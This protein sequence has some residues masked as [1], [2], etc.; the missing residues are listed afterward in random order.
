MIAENNRGVAIMMQ[1]TPDDFKRAYEIFQKLVDNRPDWLDVKVNAAIALLNMPA[2]DQPLTRE[3][4]ADLDRALRTFKEVLAVDPTNARANYCAGLLLF[5][6]GHIPEALGYFR[7]AADAKPDDAYAAYQ[8]ATCLFNGDEFDEALRWYRKAQKYDPFLASAYYG[9]FQTLQRLGKKQAADEMLAAFKRLNDNPQARKFAVQYTR[10]GPLAEAVAVNLDPLPPRPS[11]PKGPVFAEVEPLRLMG[12]MAGEIAWA[13]ADSKSPTPS[14]TICDIDGDGRPDIFI[15]GAIAQGDKRLNAVLL[16][17]DGGFQLDTQHPLAAMTDVNAVLWGDYDNDGLTDVYFCRR[18]G[19]QLWRQVEKGKWADVTEKTHTAG[20]GGNTVAGAMF[21]ADHDGDLDIFL[22]N[23]DGPNELLINNMDGTFRPIAKDR[24]IAGDGRPSRGLVIGPFTG[25]RVADI[26]VIHDQPPNEIYRNDR[27]WAYHKPEGFEA[28]LAAK[29]D[30]A[31]IADPQA[32]GRY[33]LI[34]LTQAAIAQWRPDAKDIWQSQAVAAPRSGIRENSAGKRNVDS[35]NSDQFRDSDRSQLAVTDVVGSGQLTALASDAGG[36]RCVSLTD[37]H[38]PIF[39]AK[40][41]DLACWSLFVPDAGTGPAVVGFVWRKGP[42]IW[43]P[44]PG[45]FPFMALEFSGQH[46]KNTQMRSNASG[47]GVQAAVRV[48]SHFTAINSYRN[49]SG[50]GQ[51][52]QPIAVGLGGAPAADYVSIIWPD[53][54]LQTEIGLKPGE[55]HGI[56]EQNRLPT[57]CPLVFVWNGQKFE[58]VSDCLGVGGLGYAVGPGEYAPVRPWENLLLP[59]SMQPRDGRF[60]IKIAEPMEEI[61]YLDAAAIVAYDLPPGWRMTLDERAAVNGPQ[62]TGEPRFYRDEMLPSRAINDRGEDVTEFVS[63]AD[64]SPA[65][66]GRPDPRF[67]GRCEEHSLTLTFPRPIDSHVGIPM[68][69]ANGWIEYPYSQTMFAAAQAGA[70]YHAPSLDARDSEGNWQTILPEFGYPAGMSREMSLPLAGLPKGCREIRLRTNH[71]MYWDRLS[72][73]WSEPCPEAKR[74]S[75]ALETAQLHYAGFPERTIGPQ[76]QTTFDYNRRRAIEDVRYL[77]GF[78]TRYG[79]VMEL[80][81]QTDDAV[82]TIGP[83]EEIHMEFA[84]PPRDVAIGWSRHF[85]LEAR[86][87]CKDT[88][89]FTKD[90]DT[91]EPMPHRDDSKAETL[92]HRDELHRRYNTR[93]QAGR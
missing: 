88:D 15:A 84:A 23:A 72:I 50:P 6:A 78:Y 2:T 39:E 31:V 76:R 85:V 79:D 62:P 36:W 17:R 21:D 13:A 44:G 91:V 32:I 33:E 29:F 49:Q 54:A 65:P 9:A 35:R 10:M 70:A 64:Q 47:I 37:D 40:E 20:N 58:F 93:F 90:G 27:L 26:M 57:S 22:V 8:V 12:A 46:D 34:T 59:P 51:S 81:S 41:P 83:G 28:L 3:Q 71:E 16:A 75:L 24:G 55:L 61:T 92:H 48:G 80:V 52:L 14:I 11:R 43:K 86:G 25:N 74:Q 87:W 7:K 1:L 63:A 73:A 18:G 42:V 53:G 89:L 69:V 4:T 82:A 30:A 60:Q 5:H 45:R 77:A 67:I 56:K 38:A 68:L 66:P 19:N